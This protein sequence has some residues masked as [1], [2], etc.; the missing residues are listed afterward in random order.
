MPTPRTERGRATRARILAAAA[1]LIHRRG[2]SGTS[3]DDVLAAAGA[4]KSQLYHYFGGKRGL[5]K[6]A[7]AFQEQR[8][9]DGQA[10]H[11]QHL[12]S[13]GGIAAWF[14]A[15]AESQRRGRFMD[16]CPFGTLAAEM[17]TQDEEIRRQLDRIFDAWR[18]A[19]AD[20]LRAMQ[21]RGELVPDADPEELAAF[22]VAAKQG[23]MLL[24]KTARDGRPLEVALEQALAHLKSY[25]VTPE[26][27]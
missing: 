17:A 19:L 12:D 8:I 5:V 9:L 15:I 11:L 24:A 22:V 6:D 25:A 23:G 14:D 21:Q 16:G 27:S 10:E 4:G 18:R 3:V 2:V 26:G 7:L 13:W 1:D 20:G